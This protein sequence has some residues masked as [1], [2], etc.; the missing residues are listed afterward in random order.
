MKKVII[1]AT[2]VAMVICPALLQAQTKNEPS[3]IALSVMI[4]EEIDGLSDAAKVVLSNK[5]IQIA[6]ANGISA[7][8]GFGRF[9]ITAVPALMT[10]DIVPG[11]PQQIAQNMEVTLYIG[12]Y[13]DQKI[14]ASTSISCKGV[15]TNETK[16]YIEAVKNISANAPQVRA[17]V[18]NGKKKIIDYYVT[19]CDNII[20]KAQSLA[21]QKKY[22]EAIYLLTSIPEAVPDC[23]SR[24]LVVAEGIYQQYID[25]LCNIYL[26]HAKSAWA[27]GQDASGAQKAGEYLSYIYPDAYCYSEAQMLYKEIKDKVLDDWHFVMKVYQDGIDLESQRINAWRRVGV[28]FGENQQPD[29][30]NVNWVIR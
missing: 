25:H 28:A 5:L 14:F 18:E 24:A 3:A 6:T 12:D 9:F 2:I 26:A 21:N 16:A 15:G 17:F 13:F 1:F 7:K 8:E 27:A 19:Q 23:Y 22:E 4:P 30:Y 10:K 29:V 20:N 11:P